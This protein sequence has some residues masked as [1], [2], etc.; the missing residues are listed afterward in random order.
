MSDHSPTPPTQPPSPQRVSVLIGDR[1]CATC[2]FNLVGQTVVREPHYHMLMVRCPECGTAAAMQEYP[3]LGRWANRWARVLAVL[4]VL[5]LTAFT[6][7]ASFACW[8]VSMPPVYAM[9]QP[10]ADRLG[11]EHVKWQI[12]ALEA[13]QAAKDKQAGAPAAEPA[14]ADPATP[15]PTAQPPEPVPPLAPVAS[16]QTAPT[17][18]APDPNA[19]I[20]AAARIV[21]SR[22]RG[23]EDSWKRY[24]EPEWTRTVKPRDAISAGPPWLASIDWTGLRWLLVSLPVAFVIGV[25]Y[26]ILLLGTRRARAVLVIPIVLG[27]SSCWVLVDHF[28]ANYHWGGSM[29]DIALSTFGVPLHL[30]VFAFMACAIAAGIWAGRP[31]ARLFVRVMLPPRLCGGLA[32]LWLCEGLNPPYGALARKANRI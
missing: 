24:A 16:G 9:V 12:A 2:G 8:G 3:M 28:D 15:D 20:A 19:A 21:A 23:N 25:V 7:G 30:L 27:L 17:A 32:D 1:F 10:L 6:I 4:L 14:P 18:S 22:R 11:E 26:S 31:I 5:V 29:H 13:A